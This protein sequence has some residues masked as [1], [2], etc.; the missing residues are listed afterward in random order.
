MPTA[1]AAAETAATA[2]AAAAWRRFADAANRPVA[3]E[4]AAIF[5]VAFGLLVT[6]SSLRFLAN[7]WVDTLYLAPKNHL[8][9]A[10]FNWVQPW[11]APWMHLH[12]AGLAVLGLCIALGYRH[13]IAAALFTLGFTYV[14]LIDAALYLNHYWYM[15]LAGLLVTVLPLHRR[16]SLD[17][18]AGRADRS[19]SIAVGAVWAL[20][21]QLAVVYLF[22]GAAKLNPDW[23]LEAQPLRLW[24]ADRTHLPIVGELLGEPL[25]AYAASWSGALFDLT[26]VGWLLWRRSR[27]V[28]YVAVIAFHLTTGWLFQI[29]VFPWVMIAG[30]LIFF[31]PD[32]PSRLARRSRRLRAWLSNAQRT[33]PTTSTPLRPAL[34][35]GLLALALVQ[36]AV[37]LRHL[38]Y[39]SNVRWSEQGYYLSW[40]VMLTEKA[41]HLEFEVTDPATGR[42]WLTGPELV[43]E[44]WQAAQAAIRPDLLHAAALLVADHYRTQGNMF[45]QVRA[46]AWVSMNGRP[47]QRIIDPTVDLATQPRTLAADDWILPLFPDTTATSPPLPVTAREGFRGSREGALPALGVALEAR[48]YVRTSRNSEPDVED[49]ESGAAL[50]VYDGPGERPSEVHR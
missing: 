34:I 30:T 24:L 46:N 43:L 37:P 41:G 20:R 5:R 44:D 47:A 15:T 42:T 32:W 23:L 22:A 45:P 9:Y 21:A 19:Q 1:T 31:P 33:T 6:F 18:R 13:R 7:G 39:P 26:I 14:E 36:V 3:A 49:A 10:G 28:A 29:G 35:A 25:L 27:P 17:A 38:A 8:T 2:R 4:S 48:A 16:W 40:R 50:Q 12:V 11:P